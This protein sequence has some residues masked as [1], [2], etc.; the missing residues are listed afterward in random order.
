VAGWIR[1]GTK[2]LQ[3][4]AR[5]CLHG[6]VTTIINLPLLPVSGG[7]PALK[8][9][10]MSTPS[11]GAAVFLSFFGLLF[12]VPGL[13]FLA[14]MLAGKGS[15]PNG[16]IAAVSISLFFALV[17]GGVLFAAIRGYGRSKQQAALQEANP[18]S[19]WLWR[20]DWSAR[21]A[22]SKN[23]SRATGAWILAVLGNLFLL[24][25]TI[26]MLP[27]LWK[28]GDLRMLFVLVFCL[29]GPI[30]IFL[31]IRATLRQQ[32]FGKTYFEFYSLPF[33]PGDH[34]IGRIHLKL[35]ERAEHGIDLR[36][37]CLRRMV[38]GAGDNRTTVQTVLWQSDQK[39]LADAI[40]RGPNGNTI[41]VDFA[42]P[43]DVCVTDLDNYTDKVLW[44]LHAEADVPSINYKDDF[45]IPVFRTSSSP[46]LDPASF[47]IAP[48]F[49]NISP[50]DPEPVS[51]PAVPQ[52]VIT[53]QPGGTEFYFP[54]PRNRSRAIF[55]IVFTLFWTAVVYFLWSSHAPLIFNVAFS[56]MD[57][58]LVYACLHDFLATSRIRIGNGELSYVSKML[59]IGGT[60]RVPISQIDKIV[61]VTTGQPNGTLNN[62]HSIRLV[63]KDYCQHTVVSDISSRQEA[64]WVVSQLE[65]L[66]G[67]KIDTRVL[68]ESPYGPPPQPG[69]NSNAGAFG[70]AWQPPR[71]QF[72]AATIIPFLIFVLIGGGIF[73]L[74]GW[75]FLTLRS[76]AN[77][78]RSNGRPSNP[79]GSAPA[80]RRNISK[81][82]TDSDVDRI[83]VLP[84]QQQAEELLERAIGHDQRALKLFEES[85][86]GWIGRIRLTDNMRT[87]EY[88]SQYSTDLRVRYANADINL[89]LDGWRKNEEAATLLIERAQTDPKY[90][91]TAVY[92]L[93]MLAGR[94]VAYEKIHPVLLEYAQNDSDANVRQWAVEGMRYL[95][96]DEALDE[97]FESFTQDASMN[98][99]NRAGCNISDC[100][101]FKRIQRMR[102]VPKLIDLLSGSNTNDQMRG[103][104]FMALRE[105]TDE[106]L[107]ATADAWETWYKEHGNEKIATF[108][109]LP[110]WQVRGDQ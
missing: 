61:A 22:E 6:H 23:S 66:A 109:S 54:P 56:A 38:T 58:L 49:G 100:G 89:A 39:V 81:P 94:G 31:A 16:K 20:A 60:K 108:E 7:N 101:N 19:P 34:V 91:P 92:F 77:A 95:G 41:P 88:R 25:F 65:T 45:E 55:L 80:P 75:H 74:Q 86:E 104:C 51:A 84:E 3:G 42:L 18:S 90:R 43:A 17:G 59:G 12:C 4:L 99:R 2:L 8:I 110:W 62:G 10:S 28:Q 98:V 15:T 5:A 105:I 13:F 79:P 37:S 14:A 64:R 29:V 26:V 35:N 69:I 67:L 83:L 24:P 30:L 73:A 50:D 68:V 82:M 96:T 107:P 76:S 102:M 97:L 70:P 11:R 40:G 71:K 9:E 47:S 32:R 87:L 21:R 1:P 27:M 63:T 106:N 46:A 78:W 33:S 36:L 103:W 52:V 57:L 93:G 72:A 53:D 85:V 44:Q 48:G